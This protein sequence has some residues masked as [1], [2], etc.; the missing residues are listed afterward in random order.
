MCWNHPGA[1]QPLPCWERRA[2]LFFRTT[3]LSGRAAKGAR[4][5]TRTQSARSLEYPTHSPLGLQSSAC[6]MILRLSYFGRAAGEG[7]PARRQAAFEPHL[8]RSANP[9]HSGADAAHGHSPSRSPDRG[10]VC[11][12]RDRRSSGPERRSHGRG[13][14]SHKRGT[15]SHGCGRPLPVR[16]NG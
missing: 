7:P 3:R 14:R 6:G 5:G 11:D 12:D 15:R 1:S 9:A 8:H 4:L 2:S 16:G 13:R 10:D